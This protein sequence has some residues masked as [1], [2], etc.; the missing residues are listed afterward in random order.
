MAQ[1]VLRPCQ[2]LETG[3]RVGG[4]QACAAP[5]I[6]LTSVGSEAKWAK[7]RIVRGHSPQIHFE[8][9]CVSPTYRV[10]LCCSHVETHLGSRG[11]KTEKKRF[12]F[13]AVPSVY[14]KSYCSNAT[15][16]LLPSTPY[17]TFTPRRPPH[18]GGALFW[19]RG[20]APTRLMVLNNMY[21]VRVSGFIYISP[22]SLSC[23]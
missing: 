11:L 22:Y 13:S 12:L 4:G 20:V 17:N 6:P 16:S 14:L 2:A 19:S 9:P 3:E 1:C 23:N 21:R 8:S 7:Y 5:L 15:H 10:R 18:K